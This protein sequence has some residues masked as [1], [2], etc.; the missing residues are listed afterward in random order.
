ME[1]VRNLVFSRV[2]YMWRRTLSWD[3][4]FLMPTD[5]GSFQLCAHH[6]RQGITYPQALRAA[7]G[8]PAIVSMFSLEQKKCE[9]SCCKAVSESL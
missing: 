6:R 7:A 8:M 3:G 9:K 5:V 1:D 2:I 4:S